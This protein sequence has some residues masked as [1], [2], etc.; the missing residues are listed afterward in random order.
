MNSA[1]KRETAWFYQRDLPTLED[2][3]DW[4]QERRYTNHRLKYHWERMGILDKALRWMQDMREIHG[5][6]GNKWL[7]KLAEEE[8]PPDELVAEREQEFL[9]LEEEVLDAADP[10]AATSAPTEEDVR[11]LRIRRPEKRL[12]VT[13]QMIWVSDNLYTPRKNIIAPCR[14]AAA[15]WEYYTQGN[16]CHKL[17]TL[18]AQKVIP[19]EG[20]PDKE[21]LKR[22]RRARTPLVKDIDHLLKHAKEKASK[23]V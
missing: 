17:Y 10:E 13:E 21:K 14:A 5:I 11:R 15:M 23:K 6:R 1:Y 9:D 18:L 2:Y 22:K 16:N 12:T 19:K 20:T 8:F 3:K 4:V 7:W